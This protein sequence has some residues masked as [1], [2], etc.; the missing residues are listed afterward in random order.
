MPTTA[1]DTV[2]T[3]ERVEAPP[4]IRSRDELIVRARWPQLSAEARDELLRPHA[5]VSAQTRE[6]YTVHGASG[7]TADERAM[8]AE[9]T[10]LLRSGLQRSAID[11][12]ETWL[13]SGAPDAHLAVYGTPGR[14]RT[15]A[16]T[17]LTR[18]ALRGRPAP[19]EYCYVADPEAMGHWALLAVPVGTGAPFCEAVNAAMHQLAPRWERL[20]KTTGEGDDDESEGPSAAALVHEHLDPLKESAPEPAGAYLQRLAAALIEA[21][22]GNSFPVS[23]DADCPAGRP[24]PGR[25]ASVDMCATPSVASAPVVVASLTRT[26]L[27]RVL[28]RAHGG[29]LIIPAV[30]LV[31]RDQPTNEWGILRSVLRTGLLPTRGLGEPQLPVDVRVALIG[32]VATL[33]ILERSED[34]SRLFRYRAVFEESAAWTRESE[35]AY[36]A[37]CDGAARHY[38]LP[39]FDHAAVGALIEEG[40]RRASGYNRSHL[41]TDLALLRD[42][43]MESGR[44]AQQRGNSA[45][46]DPDTL[47]GVTT[48]AADVEAVLL[49]RRD[50]Y[51]RAARESREDILSGRAIVPTAGSAIGQINGLTV[52]TVYP[53]G[54]DSRFG[55]PFRLTVTVTPG[56][57]RLVDVEREAD[58]ADRSHVAGALT[59]AG[60]LAWRYG[61][62][63]PIYT[64][65]RLRF[66]QAGSTA[67]PS[68]SA[69][70]LFALLSALGRVPL[71][72]CIAVTGAVGQ[73]G[74]V[75]VIGGI[76]DKI[77]GF[78]QICRARRASGELPDGQ[79]GIVLPA[80]NMGDLMLRA[81]VAESIADDG[82]FHIWPIADIDEGIPVLTGMSAPAVHA[83]VDATLA[84]YYELARNDLEPMP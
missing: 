28:P 24:E 19:P 34:Y 67:G 20:R 25:L 31:D 61:N 70:E 49:R 27:T 29:V 79:Y 51:S 53:P 8:Q 4:G 36:A 39:P 43:S 7:A 58:H 23:V 16:V 5:D 74:E 11:V 81:E 80:A 41:V 33:R 40:A 78:W 18:Q 82:W 60:Y 69:A 15:S 65:A 45:T 35:A 38:G 22:P 57:E 12:I 64:V 14:G 32:T 83:R 62:D 59:M 9:I 21:G 68:A 56:R 73:H 52:V 71:R 50:V 72:S 47:A 13:A 66:E 54:S 77:E 3:A 44:L 55:V 1:V 26:E 63:R 17:A 76:A 37:L 2:T 6:R 42:L 10:A 30:D 46:D 75:Q 48:A 84:R